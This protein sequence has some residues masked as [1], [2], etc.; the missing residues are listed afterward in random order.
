MQESLQKLK[1][2][3]R[4]Q[5]PNLTESQKVIANYI[6]ENTQKFALSSIRE[7]EEELKT[8]KSTIVR[9]A[10]VLGYDGFQELK[11]TFLKKIRTDLDPVNRYKVYLSSTDSESNYLETIAQESLENINSTLQVIDDSQYKKAVKLIEKAEYVYT[12]GH[13]IS[14]YLAD[15]TS[16]LLNSVAIKSTKLRY[17]GITFA[18]EIV[19]ISNKDLII[20][21]TF[22]EYSDE[23]IE[24]CAYANKK[25]IKIIAITDKMTNEIIQY[26]NVHLQALAESQISASSI[27]SPVM[28]LYS[29]CAQV[30]YD[31]KNKTLETID[32]IADIRKEHHHSKEK[33]K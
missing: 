2:R 13:G 24:A 22:P 15:L 9:L 10:Q 25:G 1:E 6:V 26:S 12:L 23:T 14:A 30:G 5:I 7:I 3:I 18:E 31:L 17:G 19:N 28:L 33:N 21:L 11:N 8:S 32:S 29:L 20:A 16:H 27:I 4:K